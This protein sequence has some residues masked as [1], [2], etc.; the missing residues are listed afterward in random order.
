MVHESSKVPF[1]VIAQ[2]MAS[3]PPSTI[4]SLM[5]TCRVYYEEGPKHLLRDGVV[6]SD[7]RDMRRFAAFIFASDS[8][9]FKFFKKL[10]LTLSRWFAPTDPVVAHIAELLASPSLCLETLI[11]RRAESM[12]SSYP[13]VRD[14]IVGLTS[15][16][17]LVVREGW[18]VAHSVVMDIRSPLSSITFSSTPP[19]LSGLPTSSTSA[20]SVQGW[21]DCHSSTLESILTDLVVRTDRPH[22]RIRKLG[23]LCDPDMPDLDIL[24][25]CDAFPNLSCLE[26]VPN[27]RPSLSSFKRYRHHSSTEIL[28][29]HSRNKE[30]QLRSGWPRLEQCSGE[31]EVLYAQGLVCEVNHLRV[32]KYF[33]IEALPLLCEVLKDTR[34]RNSA[35]VS[36]TPSTFVQHYLVC[37]NTRESHSVRWKSP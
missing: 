8:S 4:S 15:I 11:L 21:L 28:C 6:L 3:S 35:S 27:H 13:G 19:S 5:A 18:C 10:D 32:W 25:I 33:D 23:I 14:A 7:D 16:K 31:L 12:L 9:R 22:A 26:L 34:L 1:D 30:T 36:S 29:L 17:H 2:I 24:L 37:T 20:P